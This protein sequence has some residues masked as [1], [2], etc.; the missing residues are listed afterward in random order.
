MCDLF[1][2]TNHMAT[3]PLSMESIIQIF[4]LAEIDVPIKEICRRTNIARNTVKKY[5]KL[6]DGRSYKELSTKELSSLIFENDTSD[7]KGLRYHQLIKHFEDT[8][9]DLKK[10][11]VTKQLL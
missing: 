2:N 7:F 3:Q 9:V 10:T 8:A 5:L 6:L 1:Q 4:K 11:G